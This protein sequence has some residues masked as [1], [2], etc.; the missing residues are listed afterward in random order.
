MSRWVSAY[1]GAEPIRQ[2]TLDQFNKAFQSCGFQPHF[3]YPCYGMAEATLMISGGR[4]KDKPPYLT[5]AAEQLEQG[6]VVE[7]KADSQA[8]VR[9]IVGC[10]RSWL[11]MKIVVADPETHT[12]C[13]TGRV[14]EIWVSGSSVTQGYWN[15]PEKT[16]ETFDAYLIT[17]EGPFLRTG[18]LGF[19][20]A[21][22]YREIRLNIHV[23]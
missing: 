13:L 23:W 21:D 10:G 3:F 9:Q 5:V 20:Q 7:V 15:Q 6:Q 22:P 16:A 4:V 8:V 11:D 14:G 17:G 2:A 19:L 18:D 12:Q 1:S